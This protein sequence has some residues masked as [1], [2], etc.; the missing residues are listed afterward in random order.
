MS[1]VLYP[2]LIGQQHFH[3]LVKVLWA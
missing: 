2:H 1:M 3:I